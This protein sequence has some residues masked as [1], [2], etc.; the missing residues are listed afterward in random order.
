M[1]TR[2]RMDIF[3]LK[4]SHWL[5][6]PHITSDGRMVTSETLDCFIGTTY[7]RFVLNLIVL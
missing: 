5:S 6:I 4:I 1:V 2:I 3:F 7:P